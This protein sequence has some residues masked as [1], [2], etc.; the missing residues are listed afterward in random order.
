MN[1]GF[2]K[3]IVLVANADAPD[4]ASSHADRL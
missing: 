2:L 4:V 1:L 3:R